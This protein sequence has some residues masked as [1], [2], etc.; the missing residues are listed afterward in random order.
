MTLAAI[1]TTKTT[2]LA[3]AHEGANGVHANGDGDGEEAGTPYIIPDEDAPAAP[4]PVKQ[5]TPA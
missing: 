1:R 3:D 4:V 5:D 2:R